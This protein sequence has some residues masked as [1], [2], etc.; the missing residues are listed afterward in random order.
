MVSVNG[1]GSNSS[2]SVD[3]AAYMND[4][5]M[6]AEGAASSGGAAPVGPVGSPREH[7]EPPSSSIS[8]SMMEISIQ[9][10]AGAGQLA[11]V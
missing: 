2:G 10:R 9:M 3:P 4:S 11:Q 6:V 1:V 7:S 5:D 8:S